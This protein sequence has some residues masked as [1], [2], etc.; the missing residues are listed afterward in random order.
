MGDAVVLLLCRQTAA[1]WRD[2][3]FSLQPDFCFPAPTTAYYSPFPSTPISRA[4]ILPSVPARQQ[5]DYLKAR[6]TPSKHANQ[7]TTQNKMIIKKKKKN[8]KKKPTKHH[9]PKH[10][11]SRRTAAAGRDARQA[12]EASALPFPAPAQRCCCA[13][14][15]TF[16][17]RGAVRSRLCS[18]GVGQQA[19]GDG[20]FWRWDFGVAFF[21][22][23]PFFFFLLEGKRARQSPAGTRGGRGWFRQSTAQRVCHFY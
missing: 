15:P 22:L 21:V 9:H 20:A 5:S 1:C 17:G 18:R 16:R 23:V 2:L 11:S 6:T 12:D 3:G 19:R 13:D 4:S 7:Q 8:R 14:A 10:C